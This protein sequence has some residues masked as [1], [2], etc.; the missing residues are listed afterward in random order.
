MDI[1]KLLLFCYCVVGL[2]YTADEKPKC[3][4]PAQWQSNVFF[5][6]GMM[7]VVPGQANASGVFYYDYTNR[8]MRIDLGGREYTSNVSFDYTIIWKFNESAFYTVDHI[9]KTCD[10]DVGISD[11]WEQWQ[12]LPG[13]RCSYYLI[14]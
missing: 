5:D 12:G 10:R 14:F 9:N 2:A 6:F 7:M 4:F 11:F 1:L 8:Q 3:M 13:K